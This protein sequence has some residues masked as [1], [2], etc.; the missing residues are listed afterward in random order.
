MRVA[1]IERPRCGETCVNAG[2]CIPAGTVDASAVVSRATQHGMPVDP[3]PAGR[4]PALGDL[5]P[6][7]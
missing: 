4:A 5:R 2:C 7:G 6:A 3:T 1:V